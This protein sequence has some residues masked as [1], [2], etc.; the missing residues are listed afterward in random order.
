MRPFLLSWPPE[1][2]L[3]E[4][5][6]RQGTPSHNVGAFLS[7][8]K[9]WT[10]CSVSRMCQHLDFPLEQVVRRGLWV[11]IPPNLMFPGVGAK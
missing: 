8:E 3:G 11:S 2:V 7:P 10:R 9:S 4:G 1:Q 5:L 6:M